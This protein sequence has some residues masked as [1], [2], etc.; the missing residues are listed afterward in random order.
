[1]HKLII[2]LIMKIIKF[3]LK[4][5]AVLEITEFYSFVRINTNV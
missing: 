2:F 5:T 3:H 1:M 4:V